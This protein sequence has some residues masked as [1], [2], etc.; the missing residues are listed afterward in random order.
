MG[1]AMPT[2]VPA[3]A[4]VDAAMVDYDV[5]IVGGGMVGLSLA[6]ALRQT[7]LRIGIVERSDRQHPSQDT[8]A[9]AIAF[10]SAQILDQIGVWQTMQ[11]LGVAPI[12]RVVVSDQGFSRTA[13]LRREDLG[14]PALGYVVENQV[15]E[16]ALAQVVAA[17]RV[18]WL[19][20]AQ[21]ANITS[22]ISHL[23]VELEHRGELRSVSARLVVGAD[24]R[25]SWVRQWAK[26]PFSDRDYQQ[27]LIVCTILTEEAHRQ[28]AYERFH[29]SGPFAIL[30]MV[31]PP[32]QPQAH[33]SCIVWTAPAHER[34]HLLGLDDAL[35]ETLAPRI[36]PE[37]GRVLSVSP[38]VC[39]TPRCQHSRAYRAHRLVLVGDAAHA[40]H[41]V[42]GQGLN[43]GLRD[44][45]VLAAL[46]NQTLK[47][48]PGD[49][50]LLHQYQQQRQSDNATVLWGT[51]FAN[52]LFSNGWW[53]LQGLR[54]LGLMGIEHIPPLKRQL[55]R[56]AMGLAE[57]H[58][59]AVGS[60]KMQ[61]VRC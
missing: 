15:T 3:A 40:T 23:Q 24:G 8:R 4:M 20:P 53:P 57:N 26:I 42:G 22:Y 1:R 32:D 47:I 9:S 2:P 59:Q 38:R 28:T 37:L 21:V 6:A 56:Y 35:I 29:R 12:H 31:A 60:G 5:L 39:Y 7:P 19:R 30:P 50:A 61:H 13:T 36:S 27:V 41:P 17:S 52:R 46:L 45:A 10:G 58:P 14:V 54:H 18:Q 16:T 34:D 44:A 33:R 43:M 25:Q 11:T 51:D 49:A 48:D 55:M